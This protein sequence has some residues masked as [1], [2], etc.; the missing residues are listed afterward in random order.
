M[1]MRMMKMNLLVIFGCTKH[2]PKR[3]SQP[4]DDQHGDIHHAGQISR[5]MI[6]RRRDQMRRAVRNVLYNHANEVGLRAIG[7]CAVLVVFSAVFLVVIV[8]VVVHGLGALFEGSAV[9][10]GRRRG[11]RYVVGT[12]GGRRPRTHFYMQIFLMCWAFELHLRLK[13]KGECSI[14]ARQGM[15]VIDN[16][17]GQVL[18]LRFGKFSLL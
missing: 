17:F 13:P 14:Q 12:A 8:L 6:D 1:L 9:A 10:R 16:S 2:Q 7:G 5:P 15:H 4:P 11:D 3:M 18:P